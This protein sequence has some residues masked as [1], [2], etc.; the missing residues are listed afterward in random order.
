MKF[1]MKTLQRLEKNDFLL[2]D[3]VNEVKEN[4]PALT[5]K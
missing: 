1:Y 5:E 4:V 2:L 3:L